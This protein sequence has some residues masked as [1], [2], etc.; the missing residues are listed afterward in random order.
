MG[1]EEGQAVGRG[2][3]ATG[4]QLGAACRGAFGEVCE[5]RAYVGGE[6]RP[7]LPDPG[8]VGIAAADRSTGRDVVDRAG[9]PPEG[10]LDFPE[11]VGVEVRSGAALEIG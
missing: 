10:V 2:R 5:Q 7:G 1:S 11:S 9:S 4:Q 6:S 8:E 3:E